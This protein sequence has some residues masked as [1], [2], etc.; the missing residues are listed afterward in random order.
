MRFM[1][2]DNMD[3]P[4]EG[5]K[6]ARIE[7]KHQRMALFLSIIAGV[8]LWT[9]WALRRTRL[10]WV[11]IPL[12]VPMLMCL[13]NLTCYYYSF[14]MTLAALVTVRPQLGPAILATSGASTILLYSPSGYYWV[15]DRYT[16]QS[17]LFFL[18]ALLA[19]YAYSR[20]FSIAGLKAWWN[21]EPEP[22]KRPRPPRG[23]LGESASAAE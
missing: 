14:F 2:D 10:L 13:T 11:A 17:Y 7:R 18:L 19:L 6:K 4:F 3:D 21:H 22:R 12:S 15:D 20:P 5:W 9:A 8:A 23:E 16:A 1:R